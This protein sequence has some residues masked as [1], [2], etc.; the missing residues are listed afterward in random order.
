M[1]DYRTALETFVGV[2]RLTQAGKRHVDRKQLELLAKEA[3]K[4]VV[5]AY[6]HVGGPTRRGS[7]S[8]KVGGDYAPKM[9]ELLAGAVLGGGQGAD[10]TRVYKQIIAETCAA[11]ASASGRARCCATRCRCRATTRRWQAQE[12][13]R[14]GAVYEKA[15][16]ANRR[17]RRRSA[18]RLS[19]RR[20]RAGDHLAP[21]GAEDAGHRRYEFAERAYR[22]FL[23]H[24]RDDKQAYEMRFYAGEL[25]WVLQRW[26]DAAEHYTEVVEVAAGGK[27]LREA[28]FAAVLAWKN[29]LMIDDEAR[30]QEL[31]KR[32]RAPE[33]RRR[34]RQAR[35]ATDP[36]QRAE[37]DRR[38]P[39]L[40]KH[41]PDAAEL[42]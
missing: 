6:A 4:D 25:L 20:A 22:L 18:A 30:R 37:D 42:P 40:P 26:K 1:G 5:K 9:M 21:R 39:H 33:R 13:E 23:A 27:Y 35:G 10:S 24:F 3:K 29:A 41:V 17:S 14:L 32:P 7:S 28:A 12:L 31:V 36:G 19:R 8:A 15:P 11:R 2:V 34:V 38:V 16:P